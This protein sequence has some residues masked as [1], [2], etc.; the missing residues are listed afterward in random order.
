[1]Y[2]RAFLLSLLVSGC[3]Y[4][5]NPIHIATPTPEVTQTPSPNCAEVKNGTYFD[6]RLNTPCTFRLFQGVRVC[7][8]DNV[9][10]AIGG[11]CDTVGG[12]DRLWISRKANCLGDGTSNYVLSLT[13]RGV[14][15]CDDIRGI[16]EVVRDFEHFDQTINVYDL[17][18]KTCTASGLSGNHVNPVVD[19][20][21]P[22]APQFVD[23][24]GLPSTVC[25]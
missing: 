14:L 2:I 15:D 13:Q 20:A 12:P 10:I 23:E 22:P 24:K 8:P 7:I 19:I 1:M 5:E 9:A 4:P 16:I 11:I 6:R 25:D 18:L 17:E 3:S 21:P